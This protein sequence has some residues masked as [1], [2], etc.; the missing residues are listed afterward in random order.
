MMLFIVAYTIEF[1]KRGLPHVHV[2][3]W[4]TKYDRYHSTEEIDFLISVEI[5]D[6][7]SDPLR[8]EVVTT[9]MIHGPYGVVNPKSSCM[10][11]EEGNKKCK[12]FFPKYFMNEISIDSNG[13][14]IYKRWND[15]R[16]ATCRGVKI[17][18]RYTS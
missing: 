18:N 11:G 4:L 8:Y 3:L 5:P 15:G 7:E 14:P 2:V 12:N 9:F 10:K 6:K 1:Q 13:Y 17:D 16:T